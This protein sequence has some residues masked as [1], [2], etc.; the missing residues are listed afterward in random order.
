MHAAPGMNPCL[1]Q[2][3]GSNVAAGVRNEDIR[4]LLTRSDCDEA[5]PGE[6]VAELA[7]ELRLADL[8]LQ[9]RIAFPLGQLSRPLSLRCVDRA[10]AAQK[11]R[12]AGGSVVPP[13]RIEL[14]HA[15]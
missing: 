1:Q 8:N 12:F 11:G 10:P 5:V 14:V 9:G 13:T 4:S 3:E 15:V 6:V 7:E 2:Q